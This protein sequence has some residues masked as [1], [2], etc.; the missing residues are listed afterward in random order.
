[1][2]IQPRTSRTDANAPPS[3]DN[4][5]LINEAVPAADDESGANV[6]GNERLESNCAVSEGRTRQHREGGNDV[7]QSFRQVGKGN[8]NV[9]AEPN[10][11][12]FFGAHIQDSA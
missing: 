5:W 1:M 11:P 9:D 7:L 6:H 12:P 2:T 4:T 3:V 10:A 8:Q